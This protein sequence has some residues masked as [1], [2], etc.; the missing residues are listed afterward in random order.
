[1][2]ADAAGH[3]HGMIRNLERDEVKHLCIMSAADVYL[4]GPRPW[5]RLLDLIRKGL[6]NYTGQKKSRSGGDAFG[7]NTVT[8]IEGIAA[9][10]L[11]EYF[12]RKWLKTI[13]LRT[14][15]TVFHTPASIPELGAQTP[16]PER[17][18][19]IE[20]A[21]KIG[22]EKRLR[23]ARWNPE[24]RLQALEQGRFEES[25]GD[26]IERLIAHDLNGL[27]GAETPGSA[28]DKAMRQRIRRVTRTEGSRLR[29]CLFDRLRDF[30]VR[31]NCCVG[32]HALPSPVHPP[33]N[34]QD[35]RIKR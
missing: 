30:Q 8:A 28:G 34:L 24:R 26:T 22:E 1:M 29:R 10:V 13:P 2:A 31:H 6:R 12:L 11:T 21:R 17:Q 32:A 4:L 19:E 18:A 3:L 27:K 23:L 5:S 25:Q 16:S 9:H 7:T 20:G 33:G 35:P 15:T 14:L